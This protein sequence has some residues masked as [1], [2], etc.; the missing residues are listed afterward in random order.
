M[1]LITVQTDNKDG[2]LLKEISSRKD[3]ALH[4]VIF[5]SEHRKLSNTFDYIRSDSLFSTSRVRIRDRA[6]EL[7]NN[8]IKFMVADWPSFAGLQYDVA[9]CYDELDEQTYRQVLCKMLGYNNFEKSMY[10][11]KDLVSIKDA[12]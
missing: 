3:Q 10:I 9:I 5:F 12:I 7:G 2:F 4:I 11:L 6:L 8:N 1:N